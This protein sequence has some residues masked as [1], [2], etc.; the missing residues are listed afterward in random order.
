M[1]FSGVGIVEVRVRLFYYLLNF[2]FRL[3]GFALCFAWVLEIVMSRTD[4]FFVLE[5][6]VEVVVCKVIWVARIGMIRSF[7]EVVVGYR[8]YLGSVRRDS[9]LSWVGVEARS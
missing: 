9:Y 3:F 4:I 6:D 1:N 2:F 5:R 7:E 8:R